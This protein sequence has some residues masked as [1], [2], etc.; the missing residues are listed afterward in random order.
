MKANYGWITSVGLSKV[1]EE[2]E[3]KKGNTIDVAGLVRDILAKADSQGVEILL[4]TDHIEADRFAADAE[5]KTVLRDGIEDGW[6]GMDIGPETIR[7]YS[8]K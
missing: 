5:I 4:P 2:I 7:I 8:E 1:E 6:M 3:D